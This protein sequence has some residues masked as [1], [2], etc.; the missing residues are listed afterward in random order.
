MS[1]NCISN[2][3]FNDLLLIVVRISTKCWHFTAITQD[4]QL[5]ENIVG[6]IKVYALCNANDGQTQYWVHVNYNKFLKKGEKNCV[7]YERFQSTFV[8]INLSYVSRFVLEE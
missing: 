8:D 2:A 5:Q 3:P 6:W 4:L 1:Q 7:A